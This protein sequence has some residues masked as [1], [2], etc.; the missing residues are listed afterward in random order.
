MLQNTIS[1]GQ[2]LLASLEGWGSCLLYSYIN[3]HLHDSV[4][5]MYLMERFTGKHPGK[6]LKLNGGVPRMSL[7]LSFWSDLLYMAAWLLKKARDTC[8]TGFYTGRNPTDDVGDGLHHLLDIPYDVFCITAG[9]C[10]YATY[11]HGNMGGNCV[12]EGKMVTA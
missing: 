9:Q 10:Q 4:Y 8:Y 12:T 5:Q 11:W 1:N 3:T 6:W 2:A 7:G